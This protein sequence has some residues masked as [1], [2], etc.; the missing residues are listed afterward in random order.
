MA[1]DAAELLRSK[2]LNWDSPRINL[3]GTLSTNSTVWLFKAKRYILACEKA[4][5]MG[6]YWKGKL[7]NAQWEAALGRAHHAVS[8]MAQQ[9]AMLVCGML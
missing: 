8:L 2:G 4:A 3:V 7:S 6:H 9:L 1:C 5:L